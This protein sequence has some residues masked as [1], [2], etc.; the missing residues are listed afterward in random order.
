MDAQCSEKE[1][2][3]KLDC[4]WEGPYLVIS[5]LSDV[6]YRIQ[7]SRK[8]KPK[9]V[10]SNRLK[11]YLGP[12]LE[13]WIPKRQ[14]QLSKPREEESEASHVDSPVLVEDGQSAP[15]NEREGV[16]LVEAESTMREENDITPRPRN[17]DCIGADNSDQPDDSRE[18]EPCAE[19]STSSADC[20]NPEDVSSKTVLAAEV[21]PQT[22]FSVHG[23]PSRQR[24]P[25]SRYGTWVVG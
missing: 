7:K 6:V 18:P 14:T 15:I 10:H 23:R 16:E 9:V 21:V 20:H 25:P 22:D 3:A 17:A 24:K 5:V 13:R 2:N 19:L 4:P 8:A 1:R 11:P 12:P